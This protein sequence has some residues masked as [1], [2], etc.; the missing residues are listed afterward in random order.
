MQAC[1]SQLNGASPTIE[2]NHT[3]YPQKLIQLTSPT[4]EGN[5]TTY[6]QKLI[7][8]NS[9][10]PSQPNFQNLASSLVL[11]YLSRPFKNHPP[12]HYHR[13]SANLSSISK[14]N[15][16]KLCWQQALQKSAGQRTGKRTS[17]PTFPQTIQLTGCRIS[18]YLGKSRAP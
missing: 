17:E 18:T 9:T 13:V 12:Q 16:T 7:H 8:L 4:I 2:G 10:R 1:G 3:N 11:G 14:L 6:P 5:H 15:V